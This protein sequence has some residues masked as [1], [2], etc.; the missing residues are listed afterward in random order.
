MLARPAFVAATSLRKR[1]LFTLPDLSSLSPFSE[2]SKTPEDPQT[3]HERKIL[4]YRP[5]QLYAIVADVESYST[6]VPFCTGAHIISRSTL[7]TTIVT[8]KGSVPQQ[9]PQSV[10][11]AELTVGFLSFRESYTS[12]VTCKP[13]ESV[14]AVASTGTP[15]FRSLM[16]T[17]RFQPASAR[18]PHPSKSQ[19][20]LPT[21]PRP[22]QSLGPANGGPVSVQKDPDS[23]P[24]L[25]TLDLAFAFANPVHAA[26]SAAFFGQV[27]KM[28]VTAFQE[29]CLEVYGPGH[30]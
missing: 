26:V 19:F 29:R 23:G 8:S 9:A 12:R 28:M 21:D 13:N 10:L 16:T 5:S 30:K 7:P 24:T 2:P 3:Y 4:P 27:S 14:E 6:F 22:R 25:V 17:W 20:P 1:S 18:S 15:L 11:E